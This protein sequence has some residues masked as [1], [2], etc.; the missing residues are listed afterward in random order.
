MTPTI[1]HGQKMALAVERSNLNI[2]RMI[3]ENPSLIDSAIEQMEEQVAKS[4]Q[5][6]EIAESQV[7]GLEGKVKG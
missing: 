2:L 4:E 6:I 3:K 1:L 7:A 5:G